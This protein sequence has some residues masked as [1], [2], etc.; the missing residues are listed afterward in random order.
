MKKIFCTLAALALIT[1]STVAQTS[2]TT[3]R[4]GVKTTTT[5]TT[6]TTTPAKGAKVTK[7][8]GKSIKGNVVS[9][10]SYC[11]G[12]GTVLTKEQATELSKRGEMLGVVVGAAKSG[13]MY[14]VCNADGTNA[15]SKLANGGAVTVSG[16]IWSKGGVNL[17]TAESVQ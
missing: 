12:K 2:H 17:I 1:G 5:T 16:K 11:A 4:A 10:M 13:K 6:T 9:V 8:T 3:P 15:N 14:L 7:T